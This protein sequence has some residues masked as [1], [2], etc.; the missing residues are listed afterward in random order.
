[1][2]Y[3][4]LV[5]KQAYWLRVSKLKWVGIDIT[6]KL[7]LMLD[8]EQL[9]LKVRAGR[10]TIWQTRDEEVA[11]HKVRAVLGDLRDESTWHVV[12]WKRKNGL[13]LLGRTIAT[14]KRL[15]GGD[16]R[17]LA[18]VAAMMTWTNIASHVRRVQ[19]SFRTSKG[20]RG[21]THASRRGWRLVRHDQ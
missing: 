19:S 17:D 7:H 9:D 5:A 12:T 1:M 6:Y 16:D 3:A 20:A 11:R 21:G 8:R 4:T 14:M 18:V 2:K 13:L 10:S 15:L